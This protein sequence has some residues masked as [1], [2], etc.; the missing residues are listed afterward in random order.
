MNDWFEWNGHKCTE[1]GS[2]ESVHPA[3]TFPAERNT[4]TDGTNPLLLRK[5]ICT[6]KRREPPEEEKQ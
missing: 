2:H 5:Q 6:A 1:Y 4:F 3:N